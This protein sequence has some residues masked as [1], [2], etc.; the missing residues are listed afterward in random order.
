TLLARRRNITSV[1]YGPPRIFTIFALNLSDFLNY[2]LEILRGFS[3][4]SYI[5][6]YNFNVSSAISNSIISS[7]TN[8]LF[9][10]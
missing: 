1:R 3:L 10:K 7:R 8:T 6:S 9:R 5:K 2:F 4:L